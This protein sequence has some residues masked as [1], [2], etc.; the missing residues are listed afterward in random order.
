M[1]ETPQWVVKLS[2]EVLECMEGFTFFET[3]YYDPA[4]NEFECHLVEIAPVKLEIAEAGENDGEE[5]FD[6]SFDVDLL[7]LTT[8]FDTV[9]YF[10]S[11]VDY[12][13]QARMFTI[14]ATYQQRT[15]LL[16]IQTVPFEDAEVVGRIKPG[17][18]L[19]FFND[20]DAEE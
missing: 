14:E 19:E 11:G 6:S 20:V 17:G 16:N 4:S 12:E 3:Q 1:A 5:I 7:A 13:T 9:D 2:N 8:V 18:I 15:I 10:H